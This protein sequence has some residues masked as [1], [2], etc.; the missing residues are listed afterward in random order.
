MAY[1]AVLKM[2]IN[3]C[4]HFECLFKSETS[5]AHM[6]QHWTGEEH[7]SCFWPA[8]VFVQVSKYGQTQQN[9]SVR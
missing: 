9:I 5:R 4:L 7:T 8:D 6:H 3:F 2:K 1:L